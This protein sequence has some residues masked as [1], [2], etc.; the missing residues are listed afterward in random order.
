MASKTPMI[1]SIKASKIPETSSKNPPPSMTTGVAMLRIDI[2]RIK[3]TK[4][5]IPAKNAYPE[6]PIKTNELRVP[7]ILLNIDFSFRFIYLAPYHVGF[8]IT[9]S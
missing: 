9:L 6:A 5:F 2:A 8:L 3:P 4:K 7:K 1:P